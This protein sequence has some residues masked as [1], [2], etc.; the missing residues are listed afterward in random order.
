MTCICPVCHD[1]VHMHLGYIVRHGTHYHGKFDLCAGSG[2]P[3]SNVC[4]DLCG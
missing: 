3:Y 4:I 2:T 1:V